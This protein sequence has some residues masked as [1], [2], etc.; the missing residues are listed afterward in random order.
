MSILRRHSK[1]QVM[2]LYAL[3]LPALIGAIALGADVAVMYVN[4]QAAQRAADASA[5]AGANY[6]SGFAFTGT[7]ATGCSAYSDDAQKA[8]CTYAASNGLTVGANLQITEPTSSTIKVSAQ[9]TGLPYQFGR[10]VGLT[11]YD[12]SVTAVAE[13]SAPVQTVND[14][15]FPIGLQ[16]APPCTPDSLIGGQHLTFGAKFVDGIAPGNWQYL[17]VSTGHGGGTPELKNAISGGVSGSFTMGQTIY[18]EPGNKGVPVANTFAARMRSC[19]SYGG[20][21]PCSGTNPKDLLKPGDPCLVIVPVVNF[22]G[23][24]GAC[25]MTIEGFAQVYL[26]PSST[27]T[28]MVGC[29]VSAVAPDTIGSS[30]APALGPV[31]PPKLIQ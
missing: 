13:A 2:V 5:L 16:C 29:Y 9:R 18:S 30:G 8:A 23:C 31:Q 7:A 3:A 4:W 19:D 27:S 1:G 11:T 15:L 22:N 6:L 24:T 25:G 14:G 21:D 12:L 10:A 20:T 28:N 26:E 17:D